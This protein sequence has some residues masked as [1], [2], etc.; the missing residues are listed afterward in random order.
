MKQK[1][2]EI[3]LNGT[4]PHDSNSAKVGT[5]FPESNLIISGPQMH[6]RIYVH[7]LET[8][9]KQ[10]TEK[11]LPKLSQDEQMAIYESGIDLVYEGETIFI[12]SNRKN[13]ALTL[14]ADEILQEIAPKSRIKFL[15]AYDPRVQQALRDL[16]ES[17]RLACPPKNEKEM[18]RILE[19]SKRQIN[20]EAAVYYYNKET[21]TRWLTYE[22][23]LRLEKLEPKK[24]AGALHEIQEHSQR[25]NKQEN[26]EI[27]FFGADKKLFRAMDFANIHFEELTELQLKRYYG[28][29]IEKFQK[30]TPAHFR[31]DHIDDEKWRKTMSYAISRASGEIS[32]E[33]CAGLSS[34]YFM[35]VQWLPGARIHEGELLPDPIYLQERKPAQGANLE[36]ICCTQRDIVLGIIKNFFREDLSM[37]SINIGCVAFSL[38]KR[39]ASKRARRRGVYIAEVQRKDQSSAKLIRLQKTDVREFL[40]E[41]L[42]LGE[43]HLKS[44]EY[45]DYILDRNLASRQ[46]GMALLPISPGKIKE[47]YHNGKFNGKITAT[48][49]KRNYVYGTA[50]NRIPNSRFQDR[51]F[52]IEF[53]KQLGKAAASNIIVGRVSDD[54]DLLFEDG[55][56]VLEEY[57]TASQKKE[58]K[59]TFSDMTGTFADYESPIEKFLEVHA[60]PVAKRANLMAN[61]DEAAEAYISA[62]KTRLAEIKSKY[63]SQK[64]SFDNFHFESED[65]SPEYNIVP[66]WKKA[67]ERLEQ[68]NPETV[69][70]MLRSEISRQLLEKSSQTPYQQP[71]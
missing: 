33:E 60:R 35:N 49:F 16:G 69:G 2:A 52:A 15:H 46:L 25:N 28:E 1:P 14:K 26:P 20:Q 47:D 66:R 61:P 41:G 40:D 5:V 54:G 23:F 32:E 38:S 21:G 64:G 59:I 7:Q 29:L 50:T 3:V 55:D 4:E 70:N 36:D 51:E 63:E 30:A 62:F 13:L 67:L 39:A 12:R 9:N 17:Y 68:A 27:N 42:S 8:L 58:M 24:L 31:T 53:F 71:L 10:R 6:N 43:A 11:G 37:T 65:N 34:E 22:E 48:Y 44:E 56:E 45:T 18:R 19:A 57:T